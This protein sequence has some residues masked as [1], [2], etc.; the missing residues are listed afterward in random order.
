MKQIKSKDIAFAYAGS[1]VGAGF[2]S[3]QELW[4]F[5]GSYGKWGAVGFIISIILQIALCSVI[6]IYAKR[7]QIKE[8]D[9]IISPNGNK[10][11][12]WIFIFFEVF[13][14]FGVV[15]IMY[16]GVGPLLQT[17]FG[18]NEFVA[19][20][21]FAIIVTIVTFLG[22]GRIVEI[23]GYTIPILTIVTLI[24]S[25]LAFNK[26]G[27]PNILNSQVTGKT[28]LM[29]NFVVALI[30]FGVHNIFCILGMLVP[31]GNSMKE[32]SSAIKGMSLSGIVL[33]L[34]AFSVLLPI[35]SAPEYASYDLPM[36][37]LTKTISSPLFYI[38][39]IL[40]LIGMFGSATSHFISVIDFASKKS[41]LSKKGKA[42][43]IL[44]ISVL[45]FVLSTFGFSKLIS[46]L[47]PLSGYVGVV[48]LALIIYNFIKFNKNKKRSD[49]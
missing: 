22:L 34:I 11:A 13:F 6:F 16:A 41:K 2:L 46:I 43:L 45:A 1:I 14:I 7:S 40:L 19:S 21:I 49:K 30:L 24:I 12:S 42:I 5:F 29:P 4:Q 3:G 28:L 32:D 38:Y 31:L 10:I 37:E 18:I 48:A 9:L 23:L 8:F 26:Y 17:V 35:Y 44:S 20:L 47:Y 39:G 27:F 15:M 36:L 25:V 33:M